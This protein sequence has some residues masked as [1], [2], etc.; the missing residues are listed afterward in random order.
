M[1]ND[2]EVQQV[3]RH[4]RKPT[5][6]ISLDLVKQMFKKAKIEVQTLHVY[7]LYSC[8]HVLDREDD[9]TVTKYIKGVS[10]AT[11]ICPICWENTGTKH[12]LIT[13]YKRCNCGAEHTSKKV[14]YSNCCAVCSAS[15]RVARG[16][17]PDYELHSNKDQEDLDRCFCIHRKE[18]IKTYAEYACI[19]CKN[20]DRFEE[21]EGCWY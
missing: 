7:H 20:C 14:Q 6:E 4:K 18:C 15:R 2:V 19:P 8:G 11:R 13:K 9:T 3:K 16:E 21:K 17:T 1:Q 5:V 12:Q 10:R